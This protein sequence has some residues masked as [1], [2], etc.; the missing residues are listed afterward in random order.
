V[1]LLCQAL[2]ILQHTP[3]MVTKLG[4]LQLLCSWSNECPQA[5]NQLLQAQ[6]S[7]SFLLNQIGSN[8]HDETERLCHGLC[9]VLLGLAVLHNDGSVPGHSSQELTTLLEKRVGSEVFLD[10]LGDIPKHEAYIR[11]LKSPQVRAASVT[12]LTFDHMFCELFRSLDR[13]LTNIIKKSNGTPSTNGQD[14]S[15]EALSGEVE[16]YK[17]FIRQQDQKMGEF[18]SANQLLHS[19]LTKLRVQ[20]EEVCSSLQ[21]VTDQNAI[22]Q[23]QAINAVTSTPLPAQAPI[24]TTEASQSVDSVKML[25]VEA[26]L[27]HQ[28]EYIQELEARLNTD[29]ISNSELD[30]LNDNYMKLQQHSQTQALEMEN[31]KQQLGSLREIMMGKDEE[32]MKL[33]NDIPLRKSD[34]PVDR[35]ENMFMTSM[36]LES[37]KKTLNG[38]EVQLKTDEIIRLKEKHEGDL[39]TI[40]KERDEIER[41]LRETRH[42]VDALEELTKNFDKET[43]TALECELRDTKCKLEELQELR[44]SKSM[45]VADSSHLEKLLKEAEQRLNITTENLLSSRLKEQELTEEVERLKSEGL[46]SSSELKM[47]K[48][49]VVNKESDVTRLKEDVASK[50]I[51]LETVSSEQEDLLVMLADQ[52]EKISKLKETLRSLGHNVVE[53]DNDEEDIT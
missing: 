50:T 14:L 38:L 4:L 49:E 30:I 7:L 12:D 52:E 16:Q 24:Q 15:P 43:V 20:H 23:A 34:K 11:A 45:D 27:K 22:L 42:K 2:R 28:D 19:E 51:Q 48:E 31:M 36:E 29:N 37:Q 47:L 17:D 8:E 25:E 6:D 35:F 41:E 44:D 32:I 3:H 1:S 33:K 46:S 10:K 13:D 9:A 39:K 21:Q 53:S 26:K 5:V 40:E 18:V